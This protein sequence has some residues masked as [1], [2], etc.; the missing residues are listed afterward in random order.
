MTSEVDP[1]QRIQTICL[2]TLAFFAAGIA[3]YLLRA[4]LVPFVLAVFFTF[5]LSPLIDFQVR[6]LRLPRALALVDTLLLGVLAMALLAG[7]VASSV[8]EMNDKQDLYIA[9][10]GELRVKLDKVAEKLGYDLEGVVEGAQQQLEGL[11]VVVINALTSLLSDGFLV[12]IFLIFLILGRDV[13]LEEPPGGVLGKV[14][15]QIRSYLAVKVLVSAVTSALV[16]AILSIIGIDLAL[17]FALLTFF[18]NFVPNIGSVIAVLLPLPVVVLAPGVSLTEGTLAIALPFA[19]QFGMGNIVEPKLMG[20]SLDLH[21]VV[22][23]L[24][25]IFW[26][27][28]WGF[29]GMLLS[30]PLTA[31]CRILLEQ[32]SYTKPVADAMAGRLPARATTED[33][34]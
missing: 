22:V 17:V 31:A 25:L 28:L 23:L 29:V 34:A 4:M 6:R 7:V 2:L 1:Q 10:F 14:E 21:P 33:A 8:A 24:A 30:V 3:L 19:V 5:V 18:F 12:L 16:Y 15:T 20:R 32:S 13:P 11:V 26:G 9:Q 27:I